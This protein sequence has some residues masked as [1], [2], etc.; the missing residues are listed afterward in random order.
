[1]DTYTGLQ[2]KQKDEHSGGHFAYFLQRH[3][4]EQVR[5]AELRDRSGSY[6][7]IL[8]N[9]QAYLKTVDYMAYEGKVEPLRQILEQEAYVLLSQNEELVQA[10][11]AC[12]DLIGSLYN[13]YQTAIL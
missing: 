9:Y 10:Y 8:E 4:R 7:S 5:K 2:I 13:T 3:Y 11:K 12:L 6:V 1:M